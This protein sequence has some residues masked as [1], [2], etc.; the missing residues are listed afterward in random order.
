MIIKE[1]L[2]ITNNC[3]NFTM[4]PTIPFRIDL[5]LK[6]TSSN[7]KLHTGKGF[8]RFA[9]DIQESGGGILRTDVLTGKAENVKYEY[10]IDLPLGEFFDL[11]VVY[12]K[13]ATWIEINE[14]KCYF[15]SNAPYIQMLSKGELPEEF[16]NGLEI[17]LSCGTKR[18][19]VIK[20]FEV[21]KYYNDEP[22]L[23]EQEVELAMLSPF[24]WY[25]RGLPPELHNEVLL[26]DEL[27]MQTLKKAM[28]FSR[29]VDKYGYLTYKAACGFQ[30][31][32]RGF[33]TKRKH[34]V[35]WVQ[36]PIKLDLTNQM[37][38]YSKHP[39]NLQIHCSAN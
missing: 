5:T 26:L 24:E 39:L 13:S 33:G 35:N 20:S 12:G 23:T 9:G 1:D 4:K 30:Y 21:T 36:S 15:N 37:I 31:E 38:I 7:F 29:T 19:L 22:T 17:A 14:Q 3:F 25:L 2:T 8:I 28:K 10:G 16:A 34:S 11:S 27:C 32:M 18:T 6:A